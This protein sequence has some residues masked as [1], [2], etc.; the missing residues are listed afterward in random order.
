MKLITAQLVK[1]LLAFMESKCSFR[2][3]K[4]FRLCVMM[5]QPSASRP[6]TLNEFE[7]QIYR[8]AS[9]FQGFRLKF[10]AFLIHYIRRPPQSNLAINNVRPL[11]FQ[12][13][14]KRAG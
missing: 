4:S 5:I 11:A 2:S 13:P 8:T 9:S 14:L 12:G 6:I 7:S 1:K 3:L 10:C